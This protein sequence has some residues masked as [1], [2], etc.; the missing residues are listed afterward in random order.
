MLRLERPMMYVC[1]GEPI[2]YKIK[3]VL[4]PPEVPEEQ[5]VEPISIEKPISALKC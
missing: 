4:P 1:S 2:K 5:I 3:T